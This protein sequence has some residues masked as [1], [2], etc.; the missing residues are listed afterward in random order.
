MGML[1]YIYIIIYIYIEWL[2]VSNFSSRMG[3]IMP[4]AQI[5]QRSFV[6]SNR[7]GK[8][9]HPA[10]G[11]YHRK[12]IGKWRFTHYFSGDLMVNNGQ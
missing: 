10:N 5:G 6:R 3:I 7:V 2:N 9:D 1:A 12:T 11:E 8:L 4:M